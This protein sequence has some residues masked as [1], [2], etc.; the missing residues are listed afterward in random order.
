MK[1]ISCAIR[2]TVLGALLAAAAVAQGG[3]FML[4]DGRGI[5]TLP[6]AGGPAGFT[7]A[8]QSF[9]PW[10]GAGGVGDTFLL[11]GQLAGQ[12]HVLSFTGASVTTVATFSRGGRITRID[13]DDAGDLRFLWQRNGEVSLLTAPISSPAL[14][15]VFTTTQPLYAFSRPAVD[16]ASGDLFVPVGLPPT[17]YRVD[18]VGRTV[19]SLMQRPPG[20]VLFSDPE[21]GDLVVATPGGI[22]RFEPT[23]GAV[24]TVYTF[25][26]IASQIGVTDATLDQATRH[27]AVCGTYVV[28][29]LIYGFQALIDPRGRLVSA[30]LPGAPTPFSRIA[31]AHDRVFVPLTAPKRGG[32]YR[33][34]L[35]ARGQGGAPYQAAFA[36]G[37]RP[38]I[39][40]PVGTIPLAAD[41]LLLTSLAGGTSF[42]N[43]SGVLPAAASTVIEFDIRFSPPGTRLHLA[44]VTFDATGIRSILGPHSFTVR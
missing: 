33:V 17:Y 44:A 16:T 18:P 24:T 43:L 27:W 41:P 2:C 11:S 15:T 22:G 39:P 30:W 10:D 13:L 32:T 3:D 25:P 1:T 29:R 8:P 35:R 14:T 4:H 6:R 38:A 19:T 36:F 28:G 20:R 21:S 37:Q 42:R 23:T 9:A 34:Q 12:E 5:T 31:I 7:F 40:T 26:P